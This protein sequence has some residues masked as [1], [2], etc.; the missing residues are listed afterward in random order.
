MDFQNDSIDVFEFDQEWIYTI[1]FIGGS[2]ITGAVIKAY[3]NGIVLNCGTH[4]PTASILYFK[5]LSLIQ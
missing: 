2:Q 1:T 3:E 4:V 5:P